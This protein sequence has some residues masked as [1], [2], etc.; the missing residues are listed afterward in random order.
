MPHHQP[1]ATTS[2]PSDQVKRD[3]RR[4]VMLP[5]FAALADGS[6]FEIMVVDLSY[7]GCCIETPIGLLPGT[8]L[9]LA[10]LR[11]GTLISWVRWY[12]G[13]KAGLCFNAVAAPT[14]KPRLHERVELSAAIGLRRPGRQQYQ[15]TLANLTPSGCRAEFVER[16][17]EGEVIWTKLDGLEALEGRVRWV[18]GFKGGIEFTRAIHPAVFDLLLTRIS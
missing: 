8:R 14:Q 7:D 12:G 4:P 10:V 18:D 1:M 16:P 17:K 5:G 6:R 2:P 15:T 3:S 13:G 11:L 9:E